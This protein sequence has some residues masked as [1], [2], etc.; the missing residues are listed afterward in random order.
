MTT[1]IKAFGN[2]TGDVILREHS[3]SPRYEVVVILHDE[4]WS[5]GKQHEHSIV[6]TDDFVEALAEWNVAIQRL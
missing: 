3:E 6:R 4:T 1:C 5:T 2:N